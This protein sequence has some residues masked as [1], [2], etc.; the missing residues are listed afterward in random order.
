MWKP[1]HR[2]AS[3]RHGQRY[4]SDLTDAEWALIE[5]MI[6]PCLTPTPVAIAPEVPAIKRTAGG[7]FDCSNANW[8]PRRVCPPCKLEMSPGSS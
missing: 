2:E 1:E 5:P 3:E 6:P 4:P 8:L 7:Q